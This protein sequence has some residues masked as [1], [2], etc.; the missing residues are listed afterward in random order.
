MYS[1]FPPGHLISRLGFKGL[2]LAFIIYIVHSVLLT[3]NHTD[4]LLTQT[5]VKHMILPD[6]T[7]VT[8]TSQVEEPL[9]SHQPCPVMMYMLT[10][11]MLSHQLTYNPD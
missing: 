8:T 7:G 2:C 11:L 5:P 4:D 1:Y 10:H 6:F 3:Y 9:K